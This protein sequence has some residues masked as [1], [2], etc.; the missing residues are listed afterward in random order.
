MQLLTYSVVIWIGSLK[1]GPHVSLVAEAHDEAMGVTV[2][3]GVLEIGSHT[4]LEQAR[5]FGLQLFHM[6]KGN[7]NFLVC[8]PWL[9]LLHDDMKDHGSSL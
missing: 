2:T 4:N 8:R 6:L 5:D 1:V 7:F 3:I 9:G